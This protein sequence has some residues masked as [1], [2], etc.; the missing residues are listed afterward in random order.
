MA[1]GLDVIEEEVMKDRGVGGMLIV[2]VM[3]FII[4]RGDEGKALERGRYSRR[5]RC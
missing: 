3:P 4:V 5:N 1:F 2:D